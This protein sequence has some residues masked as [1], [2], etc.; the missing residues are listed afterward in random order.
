MQ[1]GMNRLLDGFFGR[2]KQGAGIE[3]TWAPAV[4]M[5]ETKDELAVK[6]ELPGLIDKDIHLSIAGDMLIL[7]GERHWDQDVKEGSYYR[8]ERWF[9]KFERALPLPI[10]IRADKV[11]SQLSRRRADGHHSEGRGNQVREHQDRHAVDG[12]ASRRTDGPVP[13]PPA[14]DQRRRRIHRGEIDKTWQ[15]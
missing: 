9:G 1:S 7:R 12:R 3:R 15:R 10:A 8:G 5:Y 6:T 2:P 14:P 11:K 13:P 4:D